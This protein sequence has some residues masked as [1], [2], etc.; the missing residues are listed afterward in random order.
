MHNIISAIY[1]ANDTYINVLPIIFNSINTTTELYISNDIFGDPMPG[2]VKKLIIVH[3]NGTV[4]VFEENAIIKFDNDT[5]K[6]SIKY[7]KKYFITFGAG[8]INY[9][10]AG[11]RLLRQATNLNLFDKTI[12]YTDMY[13]KTDKDFWDKHGTFIE[14]NKRGYGYWLWK[15]YLIKKTMDQMDNNDILVYLDCGCEIDIRKKE[16]IHNYFEIVKKDC[17]IGSFTTIERDWNKMDL[18]LE[19]DMVNDKYL[20][21]SQHE[22]GALMFL[23]CNRTR[24]LV[25]QWYDIACNYHFIDD[26]ASK[27][28]NFPSFKEH[29]HDQSIFSLLTKKY[30]LYSNRSIYPVIEYIRNT[31]GNSV[32]RNT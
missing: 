25:N 15:P 14:N 5:S 12:F 3:K 4:Y 27:N 20:K 6:L 17:I 29:R 11:N 1:G 18:I 21:T 10:E 30:N 32:L 13:L 28:Q 22:A 24:E 8:S 16:L 9:I 31:T 2:V 7:I 26:T 23:V 19:L